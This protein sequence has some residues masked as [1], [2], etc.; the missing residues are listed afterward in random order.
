MKKVHVIPGTNLYKASSLIP[1]RVHFLMIRHKVCLL[2]SCVL[3]TENGSFVPVT[4]N[5]TTMFDELLFF[6]KDTVLKSINFLFPFLMTSR[7]SAK[8]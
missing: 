6:V 8:K 7:L 4:N 3:S 2:V 1:I 5:T